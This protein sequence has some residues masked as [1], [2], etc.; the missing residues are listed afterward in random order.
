MTG[1]MQGPVNIFN[2][3]TNGSETAAT[4]ASANSFASPDHNA[5]YLNDSVAPP[6]STFGAN[7]VRDINMT[8]AL[9]NIGIWD[10]LAESTLTIRVIE[11]L[12]RLSERWKGS[13]DVQHMNESTWAGISLMHGRIEIVIKQAEEEADFD[14]EAVHFLENGTIYGLAEPAG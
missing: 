2:L 13:K 12:P 9:E 14:L 11:K 10:W 1:F 6:W 3:T 7:F 4:L 8:S 5:H